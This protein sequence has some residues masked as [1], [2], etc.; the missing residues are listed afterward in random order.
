MHATP[1]ECNVVGVD[2]GGVVAPVHTQGG[3]GPKGPSGMGASR[4]RLPMPHAP[5]AFHLV[6]ADHNVGEDG[7]EDGITREQA[8]SAE[9]APLLI[10]PYCVCEDYRCSSSPYE[11]KMQ[12]MRLV[13]DDRFGQAHEFC[14]TMTPVGAAAGVGATAAALC[15]SK[16]GRRHAG[17]L[18]GGTEH[19]LRCPSAATLTHATPRVLSVSMPPPRIRV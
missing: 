18:A 16:E 3:R 4:A 10:F 2:S 1:G 14:F 19:G 6:A 8:T 5:A 12:P 7:V 11:L 17:A 13:P 15:A 9:V